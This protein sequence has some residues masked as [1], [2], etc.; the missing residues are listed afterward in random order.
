MGYGNAAETLSGHDLGEMASGYFDFGKFGHWVS[1]GNCYR[2][3]PVEIQPRSFGDSLSDLIHMLG[4]VWRPLLMPALITSVLVAAIS[5]LVLTSTGAI[6]FIDLAFN[7]PEAIET[8]TDDQLA[9]LG[10]DFTLAFLWIAAASGLLYGFLYLVAARAVGEELSA[11]PSG[12]SVVG[13]AF[14]ALL[15]WA[16]SLVLISFGII[17]GLTLLII[18]G[19]WFG[20][21][22][23][24]VAPVLVVEDTGPV[25]AMR[26]SFDIV[27]R[28]WWE[29][30]GFLMLIG[31]I[32]GSATQ[33]IQLVAVPLFVVGNISFAFGLAIAL[34]VAAQG[35]IIA[36]IAVGTAVW[37]FNLR[38]RTDGPHQLQ[39]T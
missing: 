32:G 29:T 24:M 36:A 6:D 31:L 1:R 14:A 3:E 28:N 27:R 19:I 18:P 25:A 23:S 11:E 22:M 20:I 4:K 15:P 13:V 2:T 16:V 34:A 7:D 37:Y 30:F 35:L 9:D 8:L 21:A 5:Y 10:R 33:L 38:S 26:R 12:K 17:V 39:L